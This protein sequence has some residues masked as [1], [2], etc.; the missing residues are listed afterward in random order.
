MLSKWGGRRAAED[1]VRFVK[2]ILAC[3]KE[4]L[5]AS[6]TS[7]YAAVCYHILKNDQEWRDEIAKEI[8]HGLNSKEV[9]HWLQAPR[10]IPRFHLSC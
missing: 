2:T 10:V 8:L 3:G 4:H 9:S 7:A 6:D 1:G 5:Y